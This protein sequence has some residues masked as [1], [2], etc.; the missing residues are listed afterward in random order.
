MSFRITHPRPQL[1]RQTAFQVD[2]RDGVAEVD[3]LHPERELALRQH[4]FEV[5]EIVTATKLG[6][7]HVAELRQLA[8]DHEVTLP[9]KAKKAE[10]IAAIDASPNIAVLE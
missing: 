10:I 8:E 3:T 2:F 7:L 5:A 9:G 1:G 4:G 6:E